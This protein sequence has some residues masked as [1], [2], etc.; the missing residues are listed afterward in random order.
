M[1]W[2]GFLARRVQRAKNYTYPGRFT[3]FFTVSCCQVIRAVVDTPASTVKSYKGKITESGGSD[4]RLSAFS[5]PSASWVAP[6]L[7]TGTFT[8]RLRYR[9]A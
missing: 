8:S 9:T 2:C 5:R 3:C 6:A 7:F 1:F 4:P